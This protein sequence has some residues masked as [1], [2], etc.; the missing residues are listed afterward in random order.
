IALKQAPG[1][2]KSAELEREK[3][4][5][6]WSFDIEAAKGGGVTEVLVSAIDGHVVETKHE[7][8]EAEA[9]ERAKE[10]RES[11]ARTRKRKGPAASPSDTPGGHH[12]GASSPVCLSMSTKTTPGGTGANV[13]P[14]APACAP[15]MKSTQRGRAARAPLSPV[16]VLSSKPIQITHR[17]SEVKP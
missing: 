7:T 5:L 15:F 8:A 9:A 10:A 11:K 4:T 6:V 16:G 14:R 12:G 2:V 3:G 17:R 13:P 1:T